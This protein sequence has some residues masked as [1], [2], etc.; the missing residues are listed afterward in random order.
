MSS[1]TG[2]QKMDSLYLL[3]EVFKSLLFDLFL[4]FMKFFV[5]TKMKILKNTLESITNIKSHLSYTIHF[6]V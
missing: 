4:L 6:M 5:M 1:L 3:E 2:N